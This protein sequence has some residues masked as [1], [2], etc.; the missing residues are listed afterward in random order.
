[1]PNKA[2]PPPQ[3]HGIGG[4]D[5]LVAAHTTRLSVISRVELDQ[6]NEVAAS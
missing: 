3:N 2:R 4:A 1:M 5:G 6:N